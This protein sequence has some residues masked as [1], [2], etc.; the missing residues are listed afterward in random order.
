MPAFKHHKPDLPTAAFYAAVLLLGI[1]LFYWA[2]AQ[3]DLLDPAPDIPVVQAASDGDYS[4]VVR[5]DGTVQAI[6]DNLRAD[7]TLDAADKSYTAAVSM[8]VYNDSTDVWN[9]L[10]FRDYPSQFAEVENGGLSVIT[11][12]RDSEGRALGFSRDA[13]PTVIT[14]TLAE[15][16][17]P[18]ET[19]V[20]S[21]VYTARVPVL[22]ARFGYQ[23]MA[24]SNDFYL[25]NS[26]PVLCPYE[27]GAFVHHP[28]YAAGECFYSRMA[29]YD[30]T[31]HLPAGYTAIATG[32][33]EIWTEGAGSAARFKALGVRDFALV[34]GDDFHELSAAVD[35]V[36]VH[37]YYHS[38]RG[39]LGAQALAKAVTVLHQYDRRL[40]QYPYSQCSVVE[41]Q[42]AMEGMEYP[43]LVLYNLEPVWGVVAIRH[44]LAHQWFYGLVG[45]D[46]YAAAWI[47][48]SSAQ[49]LSNPG[50]S[51]Y[52]GIV[53]G[54]YSDYAG[55]ADY[56]RHVYYCG[57]SLYDRLEKAG[58]TRRINA[59]WREA[60]ADYAY[61]EA[62]T[63]EMVDLLVKYYGSDNAI[64]KEYIGAAY[65]ER[66]GQ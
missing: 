27:N 4:Q 61:R 1:L 50:L 19:A 58:G 54:A 18:G 62:G 8:D 45:D 14:V 49:Y 3:V 46:E 60:L 44:E 34:A 40:G 38:G 52:S 64:L 16:L 35:G 33:S 41:A 11:D 26:L 7:L 24:G 15:P 59:F 21:M 17:A 9:T 22:D 57:A 10:C 20:I 28:Y 2:D 47:D 29:N 39:A 66:A 23:S 13:D 6:R 63:Q 5:A 53:T 31:V 65:L 51:G 43:Q 32:D 12:L 25:G 36:A 55:D 48:E 30:V 56:V 42:T 37:S